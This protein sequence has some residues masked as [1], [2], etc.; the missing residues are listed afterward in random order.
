MRTY[1]PGDW[2]SQSYLKKNK[3]FSDILFWSSFNV[4]QQ[5]TFTTVVQSVHHLFV[6]HHVTSPVKTHRQEQMF[7]NIHNMFNFDQPKS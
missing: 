1:K 6:P 7:T 2:K 4:H 5:F 3:A